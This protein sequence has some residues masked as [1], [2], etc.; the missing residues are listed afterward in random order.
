MHCGAGALAIL[1]PEHPSRMWFFP[2]VNRINIQVH[3]AHARPKKY[4]HEPTVVPFKRNYLPY[5][6][7][8]CINGFIKLCVVV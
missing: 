4:I 6:D 8:Q 2:E 1:R 3:E 5:L 7:R